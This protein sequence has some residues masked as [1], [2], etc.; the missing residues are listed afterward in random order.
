MKINA[1]F[2]RS[3]P[4]GWSEWSPSGVK[5]GVPRVKIACA[6]RAGGRTL[7]LQ[8]SYEA[9]RDVTEARRDRKFA[10]Q[11]GTRILAALE[12]RIVVEPAVDGFTPA[13]LCRL[14]QLEEDANRRRLTP[15]QTMML[16]LTMTGSCLMRRRR[17]TPAPTFPRVAL[18]VPHADGL[19]DDERI[20]LLQLEKTLGLMLAPWQF[21]V[22]ESALTRS[23]T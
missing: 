3:D 20:R 10:A 13:E 4:P 23:G 17:Y 5:I 15:M 2:P 12:G 18:P 16:Q 7:L 14:L 9:M 1:D 19:T 8:Q 21:R 22:I 6:P 11:V